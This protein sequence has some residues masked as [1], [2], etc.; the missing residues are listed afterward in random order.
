MSND[1]NSDSLSYSNLEFYKKKEFRVHTLNSFNL[2]KNNSLAYYLP[3]V[4]NNYKSDFYKNIKAI[5]YN[6]RL[7]RRIRRLKVNKF[8]FIYY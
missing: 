4:I 8:E 6:K 1:K 5:T 3:S 7:S 2:F